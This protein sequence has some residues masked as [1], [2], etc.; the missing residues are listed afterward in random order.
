MPIYM[1]E[2]PRLSFI[3]FIT[4][5][6]FFTFPINAAIGRERSSKEV[7]FQG[8]DLYEDGKLDDAMELFIEVQRM[9]ARPDEVALAKEYM[10]RISYRMAGKTYTKPEKIP[11]A[12]AQPPAASTPAAAAPEARA[13]A[14]P[15]VPEEPPAPKEPPKQPQDLTPTPEALEEYVALKFRSNRLRLIGVLGKSRGATLVLKGTDKI[16]AMTIDETALFQ[17]ESGFRKDSGALLKTLTEAGYFHPKHLIKIYPS[18][19]LGRSSIL[20]LQ[21][22][23]TLAGYLSARGMAPARV[24]LDLEGTPKFS[25]SRESA[26]PKVL[27]QM[28]KSHEG[29]L[30]IVFEDFSN[31]FHKHYFFTKYLPRSSSAKEYPTVAL[32]TSRDKIDA[33]IGEGMV[34]ELFANSTPVDLAGWSLKLVSSAKETIWV[35]EGKGPALEVFYFE[36]KRDARANFEMLESGSYVLQAEGLNVTGARLR[37][38][39]RIEVLGKSPAP[40]PAPVVKNEVKPK[41]APVKVKAPAKKKIA[42]KIIVKKAPAV[43]KPAGKGQEAQPVAVTPAVTEKIDA[44]K[45]SPP[46]KNLSSVSIAFGSNDFKVSDHQKNMLSEIG[47]T[48]K[49]HPGERLSLI[50]YASPDE[51][52]PESLAEARAREVARVL[53]SEYG[54][55]GSRLNIESGLGETGQRIVSIFVEQ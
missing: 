26:I 15:S 2:R 9:G 5:I 45:G 25:L 36:G 29:K 1:K 22:A 21:R 34:I 55:A 4:F 31:P 46:V 10:N 6:T 51:D 35:Y 42:K 11:A 39:K 23:S 54:I 50:G 3:A 30:L 53:S 8:I 43:K 38:T 41:P 18:R 17:K 20:N 19:S 24:E 32:G 28:A 33:R 37:A 7:L 47:R 49:L 44:P 40:K 13:Q 27:E 52:K 48:A 12:G 14:A 16:L